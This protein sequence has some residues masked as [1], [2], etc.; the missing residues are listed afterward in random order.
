M[1][2][3]GEKKQVE[4][5]RTESVSTTRTDS[6]RYPF[7]MLIMHVLPVK[8]AHVSCTVLNLF[9]VAGFEGSGE[10]LDYFLLFS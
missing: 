6:D 1:N 3:E 5:F 9:C 4:L 7:F 10:T 2:S 8:G